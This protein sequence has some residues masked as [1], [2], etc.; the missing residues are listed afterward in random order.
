MEIRVKRF[1]CF[2]LCIWVLFG[3]LP[4]A[5]FAES[6]EDSGSIEDIDSN[7]DSTFWVEPNY[8]W[9]QS[10]DAEILSC[11][12]TGVPEEYGP[13]YYISAFAAD[14][15]L[16]DVADDAL[17]TL[18]IQSDDF[19]IDEYEAFLES[20]YGIISTSGYSLEDLENMENA[21]EEFASVLA[22]VDYSLDINAF[23]FD[24]QLLNGETQVVAHL[25]PGGFDD[26]EGGTPSVPII[27]NV[28]TEAAYD[29]QIKLMSIIPAIGQIENANALKG[30][31]TLSNY[32]LIGSFATYLIVPNGQETVKATLTFSE[33]DISVTVNDDLQEPV[34]SEDN[35]LTVSLR[36]A[37]KTS[38]NKLTDASKNVIC[39]T[40]ED[41]EKTYSRI[42]TIW[43]VN[44]RF[45][46]LP[47]RVVDYLCINSQYTNDRSM[48]GD[49]GTKAIRSLVGSN[50]S[51][52]G[53]A[54]GPV[55]LGNFGGYIIYQYDDA[56]YDDPH[57]PYGIDFITFGN[58]VEGSNEFGEVGQV[59]VSEDGNDWYALAGGMHYEDYADWA[60]Q[61][62]YAKKTD[63]TTSW[64]D[65]QGNQSNEDVEKFYYPLPEYYPW[66]TFAAAEENTITLEGIYFSE[67]YVDETGHTRA[68]FAGF[69]YTD[70][71]QRGTTL[72]E[73]TGKWSV[74]WPDTYESDYENYAR[75][76]AGSPYDPMQLDDRTGR[77]FVYT[78]D[79]MDLAWAVDSEGQPKCFPNGIHFVKIVTATN[80]VNSSFGE[81]STE[82]NMVRMARA[83]ASA[84]GVSKPAS[85]SI[86]GN[87]V[88]KN[89]GTTVNGTPVGERKNVFC[90]D[91]IA[92]DGEFEVKVDAPEGSHVYINNN[93]E[94]SVTYD[95]IPGHDIVRVIVQ[96]DECE[97][98]IYVFNLREMTDKEKADA[99][100]AE[101]AK[102]VDEKIEAIGDV[103][104]ERTAVIKAA[105]E[106]YEAL[107]DAAKDK[108][109]KLDKL[110]AAEAKLKELQEAASKEKTDA[111]AAKG[112]SD[113][114]AAL[115]DDI[116][117]DDEKA[118]ESARAAYNALTDD[119]KALVT[120]EDALKAAVEKIAQLKEDTPKAQEVEKQI[121]AIGEVTKYKEEEIQSARIAYEA[122]TDSQK[123]LVDNLAALDAAEA[124]LEDLKNGSGSDDTIKVTFRLIGST[125]S[126]NDVD[127]SKGEEGY[128]TAEYQN[129]IKTRTY[130]MHSDDSVYDLFVKATSDAGIESK[131]ANK[132]YVSAVKAPDSLGGYWL[133]EFS[134]GKYSGW[135]YTMDGKHTNAIKDQKLKD[136]ADVVFHYVNDYRYEVEDWFDEPAYPSAAT[137]GTFYNRWLEAAD[138]RPGSQGGTTPVD[139]AAEQ[140]VETPE[141]PGGAADRFIDVEANDWFAGSVDYAVEKGFMTGTG[142]DTFSPDKELTRGMLVSML[143]SLEGVPA[144]DGKTA[145]GDVKTSDWFAK[146][147]DW[148]VE[149]GV[150]A[151]YGEDFGPDD[152]ITREQMV[153]MLY[154][155]AKL[156]GY[157]LAEGADLS[158][159]KD[160]DE[161]SAWAL[162]AVRWAKG[163]NL[164]TGR[165]ADKL[166]PKGTTTRAEAAT[167]LRNF[168]EN[169]AK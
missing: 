27:L 63:V 102:A 73:E 50:Y 44:Q 53:N 32:Y 136:G 123:A 8:I 127:L 36:A 96:N 15:I 40:K 78:T 128:Y 39:I 148:A 1:L 157:T 113:A 35:T 135:M 12:P 58:S 94:T 62:T 9:V 10:P 33:S 139:P 101:S 137:D 65:S 41:D 158:A 118:V 160:V 131:G 70:L 47:D 13:D 66:H 20:G 130:T 86:D 7:I 79:G 124:A 61:V 169:V 167:I 168:L 120:N 159:Y 69:G 2:F 57:N 52:G 162:E 140:P 71:G 99:A 117:L 109:E 108:V 103:T 126:T 45:D 88:V 100:A 11:T 29:R 105:R 141:N 26:F 31:Q 82:V 6:A 133:E 146:G 152:D 163:A 16:S 149:N 138:V 5:T 164:I 151:G 143:Y 3:S 121:A 97:P 107:D 72:D 125:K 38:D 122:L 19:S 85:I 43:A 56:I 59:W 49:Y 155:Y 114:I 17:I 147:V 77:M 14:I 42:Y 60:Y 75:N 119:Q 55:S 142:A 156:K 165:S 92:V 54:S 74:T 110:I 76:I 154:G 111:A 28:Y 67:S 153:V 87:E 91:D 25:Y 90:F 150:A 132:G 166:A 84:V 4:A 145:F 30:L 24:A 93:P 129:W 34:S 161:I 89:D 106:A 48:A 115:G 98:L 144:E 95:K 80:I 23:L 134:N 83:N 116:S 81:K 104:L 37:P 51:M 18:A 68:P 112:V 46:D 64:Q 21:K 22:G